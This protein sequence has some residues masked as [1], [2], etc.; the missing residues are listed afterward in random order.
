[1]GG[2]VI[3]PVKLKDVIELLDILDDNFRAFYA[4]ETGNVFYLSVDDLRIAEDSEEDDDFADYPEWQKES[5][6]EAIE[7]VENWEDYIELPD[8][9]EINEY[10]IMEKFTLSIEDQRICND[11][12][13]SI[14]GNG[15]FRRF[16]DKIYH[17]SL[18]KDWY[19]FR[20][21]ALREIA[22]AWCEENEI[23]YF[24]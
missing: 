6:K 14:K 11:I 13:Y 20:D 18:D 17:Y 10:R 2:I 24:E 7:I 1:M 22:I 8:R 15:A 19:S 3:K 12:Y 5:I 4:K 23:I 9:F 21:N 16:K